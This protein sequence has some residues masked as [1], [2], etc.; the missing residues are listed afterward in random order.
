MLLLTKY[1]VVC[2]PVCHSS[3]PWPLQG[4]K[5]GSSHAT[6]PRLHDVA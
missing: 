5:N 2:L 6:I 3:E 1:N 4:C